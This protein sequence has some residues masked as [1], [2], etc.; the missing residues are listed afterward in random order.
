M[1]EGTWFIERKI[2]GAGIARLCHIGHNHAILWHRFA[3]SIQKSHVVPVLLPH[4]L[5]ERSLYTR[6]F[7]SA[8]RTFSRR[9]L[10]RGQQPI[11]RETRVGN[12]TRCR[13]EE[14]ANIRW[15]AV[16]L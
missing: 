13:R 7:F 12:H 8:R 3:H 2:F 9:V 11:K 10:Q 6:Y 1:D 14:T 15:F 5:N 4:V 16:D